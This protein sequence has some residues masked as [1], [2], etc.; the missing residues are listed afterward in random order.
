MSPACLCRCFAFRL[1]LCTQVSTLQQTNNNNNK[2]PNPGPKLPACTLCSRH[3]TCPLPASRNPPLYLLSRPPAY[4]LT[5][6]LILSPLASSSA[7]SP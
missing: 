5:G 6:S 1:C 2:A 3:T 7:G 4:S